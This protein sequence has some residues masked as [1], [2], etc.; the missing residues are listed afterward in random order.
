[1]MR[2]GAKWFIGLLF[3]AMLVMLLVPIVSG[4]FVMM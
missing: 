4:W 3:L 1:M 2:T